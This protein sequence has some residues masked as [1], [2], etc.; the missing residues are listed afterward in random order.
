MSVRS[1]R[2]V[3][4]AVGRSEKSRSVT[5]EPSLLAVS[6]I[7]PSSLNNQLT[8]TDVHVLDAM[9][10][11]AAQVTV[12]VSQAARCDA[13]VTL[14]L[15]RAL[16]PCCLTL[17]WRITD[18]VTQFWQYTM[19]PKRCLGWWFAHY[20]VYKCCLITYKY[21]QV[22]SLLKCPKMLPVQVTLVS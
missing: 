15:C 5:E 2:R 14:M 19:I 22:G 10:R 7:L 17:G 21:L 4:A 16:L 18:N 13:E 3:P 9:P 11:N 6:Q 12:T 20:V 8:V 1:W